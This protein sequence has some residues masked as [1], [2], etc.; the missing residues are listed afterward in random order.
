MANR[1]KM[2]GERNGSEGLVHAATMLAPSHTKRNQDQALCNQIA[3]LLRE[4]A[5]LQRPIKQALECIKDLEFIGKRA[6]VKEALALDEW[7][8]KLIRLRAL[9]R[10]KH[11]LIDK[12]N[13]KRELLNY[14]PSNRIHESDKPLLGKP[15]S[16][17]AIASNRAYMRI[18]K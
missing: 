13:A 12:A 8:K 5:A 15:Q 17:F 2:L 3:S 11:G 14:S 7:R 10:K 9:E 1:G 4:I 16:N 6:T 18:E